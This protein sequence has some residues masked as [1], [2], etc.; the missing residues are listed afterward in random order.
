MK[1]KEI[2]DYLDYEGIRYH[3]SGDLNFNVI[4]FCP[5]KELSPQAITW[6]RQL[7]EDT[8]GVLSSQINLLVV[9]P[10]SDSE[11]TLPCNII[12]VDNPHKTFFKIVEHFFY[13]PI[14][15]NHS[16]NSIIE[17]THIGQNLSVGA[18]SFIGPNVKIGNNCMI[19]NH[20]SIEGNVTIGNNVI[21]DSGARIGTWGFGHYLN[22]DRTSTM[23]PHLGG[24]TIGDCVF[25]GADTVVSRGTLSDT[26]I[27][28]H[29]KIDAQCCI[30]HNAE[31]EER[32]IITG[33]VGI[34][35]SALIKK[36]CWLAPRCVINAGVTVGENAFIGINSVVT[37]DIPDNQYAFGIPARV[38]KEN[39]DT[40]YKI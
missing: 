24:V 30:C 40:R 9:L 17:T 27:K 13:K 16:N 8:Y 2:T 1:A 5:L 28:S 32:V 36:D 7:S 19:G 35:G 11:Y 15:T 37:K 6:V 3:F 33:G 26:I 20:V 22:D 12:M 4:T 21:I 14:K 34:A 38:I 10:Y 18:F 25:V 31:I 23:I 29:V 39:S